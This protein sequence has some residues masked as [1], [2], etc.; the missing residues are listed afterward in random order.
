MRTLI[1]ILLSGVTLVV[2]A[3]EP[4]DLRLAPAFGVEIPFG[5]GA[6]T[7]PRLDLSLGLGTGGAAGPALL[8]ASLAPGRSRLTVAGLPVLAQRPERLAAADD[9]GS[10]KAGAITTI[11]VLATGAV[12]ALVYQ[13]V[14]GFGEAVGEGVGE[15]M[16]PFPAEGEDGDGGDGNGEGGDGE[17]CVTDLCVPLV[18]GTGRGAQPSY[19]RELPM[20]GMGDLLPSE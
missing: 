5:G 20:G 13:G 6:E 4:E 18:G 1:A 7:A 3:R 16:T 11:S 10:G 14:K 12:V 17:I 15:A 2:P 19:E 8:G 9:G